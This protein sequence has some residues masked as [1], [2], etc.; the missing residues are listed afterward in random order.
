MKKINKRQ[1]NGGLTAVSC[2]ADDAPLSVVSLIIRGYPLSNLFVVGGAHREISVCCHYEI[3]TNQYPFLS[4]I[5][6]HARANVKHFFKKI[7]P[8]LMRQAGDR[9]HCYTLLCCKDCAGAGRLRRRMCGKCRKLVRWL[10]D[11]E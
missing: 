1:R 5:L 10:Q 8:R 7:F 3:H 9:W 2:P 6:P 11:K 4:I